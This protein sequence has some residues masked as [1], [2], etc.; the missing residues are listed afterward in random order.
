MEVESAQ[1]EDDDALV[2]LEA[3]EEK[4]GRQKEALSHEQ[5]ELATR[6]NT[7]I[8]TR[9]QQVGRI[10]AKMLAAYDSTRQKR[11]GIAVAPVQGGQC[12]VCGVRVSSSKV[13]AAQNGA[14]VRCGSCDRILVIRS[15]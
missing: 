15:S 1:Q 13:S 3:L 10:D 2:R 5:D 14:L 7:L 12:Q 11:G 8:A 6:L 4:W 9:Q